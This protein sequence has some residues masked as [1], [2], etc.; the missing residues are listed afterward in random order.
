MEYDYTHY[1]SLFLSLCCFLSLSH[2]HRYRERTKRDICL[3]QRYIFTETETER[4]REGRMV[5]EQEVERKKDRDQEWWKDC[6]TYTL[7]LKKTGWMCCLPINTIFCVKILG[8]KYS[9]CRPNWSDP[10]MPLVGAMTFSCTMANP[11]SC[12]KYQTFTIQ[13]ITCI[14]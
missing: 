9:G 4:E 11:S 13:G 6:Y 3:Y 10:T 1:P 2:T 14:L 8:W 5:R 7:G 12:T